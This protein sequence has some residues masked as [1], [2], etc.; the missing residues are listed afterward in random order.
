MECFAE[1]R[2]K[3]RERDFL[4]GK[5]GHWNAWT[6]RETVKR[7]KNNRCDRCSLSSWQDVPIPLE[8]HH[9]DGD[10]HNNSPDNVELLCPNCHSL[11][12]NYRSKNRMSTRKR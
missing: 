5:P 3:A 8:I 7:L 1:Y 9:I 11:T 6:L 2:T 12:P 4:S 10:C